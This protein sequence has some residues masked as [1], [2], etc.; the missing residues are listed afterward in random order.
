M[1]I[2]W[3]VDKQFDIALDRVTWTQV[4]RYLQKNHDV[5]LVSGYRRDKP[6][7]NELR[8]DII[9][10]DNVLNIKIIKRIMIYCWQFRNYE[11]LLLRY[12]PEAVIFNT[13]D[14]FLV[15]KA[16]KLRF[17]YGHKLYLDIRT[18][19][20]WPNRWQRAAEELMFRATLKLAAKHFDGVSY[21]TQAL[22]DYCQKKYRLPSHRTEIWSSGVDLDIFKPGEQKGSSKIFRIIYHGSIAENRG[23]DNAIKA[24]SLLKN[25]PVELIFLGTGT[26]LNKLK[27]LVGKLGLEGKVLF[28]SPVPHRVVAS[29]IRQASAGILPLP[30]VDDWNVSS[31]LKLFEYLACGKPVI[32]TK[33]PAHLNIIGGKS[34]VFWAEESTPYAI[35]Q[36]IIKAMNATDKMMLLGRE[37]RRFVEE[38]YSWQRQAEKLEKFVLGEGRAMDV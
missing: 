36:A 6:R 17:I 1:K 11:N 16:I 13:N 5:F 15:K 30:R 37:A 21:I 8:N 27:N 26:G 24:V 7:F 3:F 38:S 19:P 31:P 35:T 4:L 12:K 10:I 9:Y 18:L 14:F 22:R 28:Y 20:V 32:V 33:I 34:F 2:L 23:L 29:H 25:E